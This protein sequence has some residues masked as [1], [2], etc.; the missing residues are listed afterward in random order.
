MVRGKLAKKAQVTIWI[1]LAIV[2]VAA[3]ALIFL[4]KIPEKIFPPAATPTMLLQDCIKD[5]LDAT[6]GN[7]SNRGGSINPVNAI[8]YKGEKIEYLCY[9][10]QYYQTCKNQQPMLKQHMEREIL[11][12]IEPEAKRCVGELK[13]ELT[14]RGYDVSGKE[15]VSVEI[16]QNNVR[17]SVSGF[18]A[19]KEETAEIYDKF[20]AV[21][22]SSIYD[23]VMMT[24]S[25]LNFEARYGDSDTM[26]YMIYYPT[27]KVEKYKQSDG[28]KIY[29]LADRNTGESFTFATRSLSWPAGYGFGQTYTPVSV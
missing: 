7:I 4:L 29:I 15:D 20:E 28:S 27:M 21:K 17:V 3:I 13:Q 26:T 11:E 2:L 23:L 1:I 6:I 24:T 10:N 18:S 19:R 12:A 5:K 8:M 14:S 25:I 22:P 16:T 9:T